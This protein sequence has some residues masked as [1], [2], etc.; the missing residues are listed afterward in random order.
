S[1]E[2]IHEIRARSATEVQGHAD[3]PTRDLSE[4][5]HLVKRGVTNGFALLVGVVDKSVVQESF[6]HL[7]IVV[8]MHADVPLCDALQRNPV[9]IGKL[10]AEHEAIDLFVGE[11]LEVVLLHPF[12]EPRDELLQCRLI[13]EI[14]W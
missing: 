13:E 11:A 7:R 5:N 8:A 1:L 9:S 6:G 12:L 3:R 10:R 2:D 14:S 4:N